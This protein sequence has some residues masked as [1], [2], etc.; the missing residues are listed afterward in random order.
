MVAMRVRLVA[1]AVAALRSG[2]LPPN[3]AL[4]REARALAHRLPLV[5]NPNFTHHF[6]NVFIFILTFFLLLFQI[7]TF[8][9]NF[10]FTAMQRRRFD[11]LPGQH[12]QRVQRY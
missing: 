11:D 3:A 8:F 1:R 2:E 10:T 6:Y 9:N 4:L 5:D 12:H 7:L